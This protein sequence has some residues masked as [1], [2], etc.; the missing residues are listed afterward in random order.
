MDEEGAAPDD[1]CSTGRATECIAQQSLPVALTL[2]AF[3][4]SEAG[5]QDDRDRVTPLSFHH[6]RGSIFRRDRRRCKAVI[7]DY[8]IAACQHIGPGSSARLILQSVLDQ[9]VVGRQLATIKSRDL[10]GFC[11]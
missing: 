6:T 7:A 9:K 1:L 2:L 5:H 8:A 3:I 4:N 10:T 11:Q